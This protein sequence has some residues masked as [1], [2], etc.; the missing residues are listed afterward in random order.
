MLEI[1]VVDDSEF[2]RAVVKKVFRA[3]GN[4]HAEYVTS[5]DVALTRLNEQKFDLLLTDLHMPQMSGLAL[6]ERVRKLEHPVPVVVMTSKGSEETA[7]Q[8]L[9]LGASNYVVK[10]NMIH[11]LPGIV[12]SVVRSARSVQTESALLGCLQQSSFHFSIPNDRQL[13]R[14]AISYLQSL[15]EKFGKIPEA[16]RIRLGIC[17]EE[18]L[19]NAMVHGNLEVSSSLRE[20]GGAAYDEL[21]DLRISQYPYC[22]R[23]IDIELTFS[24]AELVFTIRDEGP[25]FDIQ[26]VP[27]PTDPENL[28]KPSG[29]GLMLIRLFMDEVHHNAA[30]NEITLVKRLKPAEP[31]DTCELEAVAEAV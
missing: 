8:A 20:D 25:G 13:V 14:G 7:I 11:D 26:A 27:D 21:I 2:D 18:S 28:S 15:A 5:G 1:L 3:L 4:W 31:A 22:N 30:G 19:L 17:L 23:M 10:M 12:D 16:D 9:R 24:I 29:R 6:L